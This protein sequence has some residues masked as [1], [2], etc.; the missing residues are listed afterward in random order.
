MLKGFTF[1]IPIKN[2]MVEEVI[3]AWRNDIAFP[4]SVCRK[5]L[6]DNGTEFKNELFSHV[7]K[8]LG[9]ERKIYT[10]PYRPQSN[11][12]VEGFH[13]F[14]KACMVKHI[15]RHREWDDIIPLPTASYNW[16]SN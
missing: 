5:L 1:G 15:S 12:I 16:T 9:I 3:T 13:K 2:M 6:T 11:G 14:L 8:E 4:F 7:A 10:P